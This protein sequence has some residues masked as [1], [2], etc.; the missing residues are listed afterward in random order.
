M[1]QNHFLPSLIGI[2]SFEI[3]GD[4]RNLL[5]YSVKTGGLTVHNPCRTAEYALK[6]SK[7]MTRHI[8]TSLVENEVLFDP[9]E[10]R[11]AVSLAS[12]CAR[13]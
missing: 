9:N 7:T 5:T 6:T 1:I 2:P 4:Y 8:I 13:K 10:H 3:D 12:V 11:W